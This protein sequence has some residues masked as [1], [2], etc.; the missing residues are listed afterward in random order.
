MVWKRIII[1]T[2]MLFVTT[3]VIGAVFF[4]VHSD[5]W[6]RSFPLIGETSA[7]FVIL[8][9]QLALVCVI[10]PIF[11]S[12]FF[13]KTYEKKMLLIPLVYVILSFM[14]FLSFSYTQGASFGEVMKFGTNETIDFGTGITASVLAS[15]PISTFS[16]AA[17]YSFMERSEVLPWYFSIMA[18][19]MG[20]I[21]F[22]LSFY[23]GFIRTG[24]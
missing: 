1:H 11:Y 19:V 5:P 4:P 2:L 14:V 23:L 24:E 17:E 18:A 22:F 7:Y 21:A 10:I 9:V 16:S 8:I 20:L 15:N 12:Y 13:V 3:W 6:I